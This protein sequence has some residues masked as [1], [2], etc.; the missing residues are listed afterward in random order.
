MWGGIPEPAGRDPALERLQRRVGRRIKELRMACGWSQ[1]DLADGAEISRTFVGTI[2]IGRKRATLRTLFKIARALRVPISDLFRHPNGKR[3]DGSRRRGRAR[4]RDRGK[5]EETP[6]G[7]RERA[8]LA[9]LRV[10][11]AKG[12]G[13]EFLRP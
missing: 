6:A 8:R 4:G 5:G 3:S 13:A 12:K 1:E 10:L 9:R 7:A 2:E 11:G